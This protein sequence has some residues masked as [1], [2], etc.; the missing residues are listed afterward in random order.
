MGRWAHVFCL[1]LIIVALAKSEP[2][3]S[4]GFCGTKG[5]VSG[6]LN[7]YSP[8]I[9]SI[10]GQKKMWSGGWLSSPGA[11][12]LFV[13]NVAANGSI[14]S[15]QPIQWTSNCGPQGCGY[16]NGVV[17]TYHVND[18]TV[19]RHPTQPWYM[20]YYTA[21]HNSFA[22]AEQMTNRNWVG[23]AVS[24]DGQRWTDLGIIIGQNNG[25][26]NR[27]AWSPSAIYK[28]N[29]LWLYYH[30]NTSLG[31]AHNIYRT[32]LNRINAVVSEVTEKL[33]FY[34]LI[35]VCTSNSSLCVLCEQGMASKSLC[36]YESRYVVASPQLINVDVSYQNPY[37]VLLANDISVNPGIQRWISVDGLTWVEHPSDVNP[38]V[39]ASSSSAFIAPHA[40]TLSWDA[41]NIYFGFGPDIYHSTSMHTWQFSTFGN[42]AP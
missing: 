31:Q 40:E 19:I 22:T 42:C 34:N 16:V 15:P 8:T 17:P 2:V 12:Q 13:S 5:Y 18:P 28:D 14:S 23:A 7:I 6:F 35:S 37:W 4:A 3:S 11:D 36:T 38:I 29:Q 9:L 27:G 26:D 1:V 25:Y 32:R 33:N 41:Y 21:L 24:T 30:S 39:R 20:M 10:N